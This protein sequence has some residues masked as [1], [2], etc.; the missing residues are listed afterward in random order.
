MALSFHYSE[1]PPHRR[2]ALV[3]HDN[4]RVSPLGCIAW[5]AFEVWNENWVDKPHDGK[6]CDVA[7]SVMERPV[8]SVFS[9]DPCSV[10]D[11]AFWCLARHHRSP[12][13]G[14]AWLPPRSPEQR[15][16]CGPRDRPAPELPEGK[17]GAAV[18]RGRC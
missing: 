6:R 16:S 4:R 14:N 1:Y 5:E 18:D 9:R 12:R 11:A 3:V 17:S 10:M 13:I 7:E 15:R 2:I 8:G